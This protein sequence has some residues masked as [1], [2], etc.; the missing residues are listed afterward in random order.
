MEGS[1]GGGAYLRLATGFLLSFPPS[2]PPSFLCPASIQLLCHP[3]CIRSVELGTRVLGPE[4]RVLRPKAQ[5]LEFEAEALKPEAEAL[6]PE[7]EALEPKVWASQEPELGLRGGVH[8]S[9][10]LCLPLPL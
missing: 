5:V 10:P 6:E 3:D 9:L 8:L 4:V 1:K 7:V 2:F